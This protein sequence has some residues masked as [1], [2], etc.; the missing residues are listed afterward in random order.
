MESIKKNRKHLPCPFRLE[1][2][3]ALERTLC[4][5]HTGNA[6]ALA[7]SLMNPL[8]LSRGLVKDGFPMLHQSIF[9]QPTLSSA[10][11]R[12]LEV[13]TRNWP[14]KDNYPAVASRRAQILTYSLEHYMASPFLV[15]D[16]GFRRGRAH[17]TFFL[18]TYQAN[19]RINH[20]LK[21]GVPN[22]SYVGV[23]EEIEQEATKAIEVCKVALEALFEDTKHLVARGVRADIQS[24]KVSAR[25]K[26]ELSEILDR[27]AIR[28][29]SL[30][31]WLKCRYPLAYG[32][33]ERDDVYRLILLAVSPDENSVAHGL[34][35]WEAFCT[36]RTTLAESLLNMVRP[37]DPTPPKAP[38]LRKGSFLP[39]LKVAVRAITEMFDCFE[40]SQ[41]K[42]VVVRILKTS[43]KEYKVMLF[44][45]PKPRANSRGAPNASP[46]WDSWGN[47]G[48]ADKSSGRSAEGASSLSS[49][50]VVVS[51]TTVAFNNAFASDSNA[52]WT[53][54]HLDLN[55]LHLVLHSTPLPDDF[56]K[57]APVQNAVVDD[58]Y[59]WVRENYDGTKPVH[60]LALL[61]GIIVASSLLPYLF[62]PTNLKGR[63]AKAG[64]KEAVR[65]AFEDV[66]WIMKA[67]RG[68]MT[69]RAI[70]VAMVT[71]HI[72]AVYEENSPLRKSMSAS[73]RGGLGDAWR[74]KH[75]ERFVPPARF[76][77]EPHTTGTSDEGHHVHDAHPGRGP[78]GTRRG[79]LRKG[80]V[81]KAL[82]MSLGQGGGDAVR[83]AS[84]EAGV[85]AVRGL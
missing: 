11:D 64:S 16:D 77:A 47:L 22:A 8:G 25:S 82:G 66:E 55:T 62:V 73:K 1:L 41:R 21:V 14:L 29:S 48:L 17:R 76:L 37:R 13:D 9:V 43:L 59:R 78:V 80:H 79:C 19:L 7:T 75:C 83:R 23:S 20:V 81:R 24:K 57:P 33:R 69:D 34:P 50:R 5:C 39:V 71:T 60:H 2:L 10:I 18:Q 4:F 72:I 3:A 35:N 61:V 85:H 12:G 51:P 63:F 84:G 31:A 67:Q 58:T 53:A 28:E 74:E 70:F 44:P 38:V 42:T 49:R 6:A 56:F 30:A 36:N 46:V 52:P 54:N 68:G 15:A 32:N 65:E 45:A 26:T 40:E 27:A